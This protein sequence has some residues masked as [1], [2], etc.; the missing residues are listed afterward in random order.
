MTMTRSGAPVQGACGDGKTVTSA[1]SVQ[2]SDAAAAGDLASE[3]DPPAISNNAVV[4]AAKRRPTNIW[5]Y[6][7]A[8][9]PGTRI[10][11]AGWPDGK[12]PN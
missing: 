7:P 1:A 10:N 5:I 2:L 4:A 9:V 6:N 11:P 3:K 12:I 8:K